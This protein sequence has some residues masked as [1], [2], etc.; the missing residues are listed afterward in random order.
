MN[1]FKA[2]FWN[3]LNTVT[4]TSPFTRLTNRCTLLEM[5][6]YLYLFCFETGHI[7]QSAVANETVASIKRRNFIG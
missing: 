6:A 2:L 7:I 1:T 3:L 5:T 4:I